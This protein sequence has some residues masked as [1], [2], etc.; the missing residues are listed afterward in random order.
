MR[1]VSYSY[2]GQVSLH[3]S[4]P[5]TFEMGEIL[6]FCWDGVRNL[7]QLSCIGG[8]RVVEEQQ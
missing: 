2:C 5:I 1:V 6:D 4:N 3:P 8:G 7:F